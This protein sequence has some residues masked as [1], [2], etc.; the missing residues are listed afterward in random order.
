MKTLFDFI[1]IL[2]SPM[3]DIVIIVYYTRLIT[4]K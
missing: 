1:V 2:I 3:Y 4:N